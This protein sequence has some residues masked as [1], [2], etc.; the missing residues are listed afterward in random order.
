[1]EPASPALVGGFFTTEPPEKLRTYSFNQMLH[2]LLWGPVKSLSVLREVSSGIP[3]GS[4]QL[5]IL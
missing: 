2:N 1:M 4:A 5:S 3:R